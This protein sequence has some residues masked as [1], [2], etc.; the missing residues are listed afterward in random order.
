[1]LFLLTRLEFAQNIPAH[2]FNGCNGNKRNPR[3]T[4]F[5]YSLSSHVLDVPRSRAIS[6][7]VGW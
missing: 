4:R 5:V 7:R 1:M 3:G 6:T 2:Y